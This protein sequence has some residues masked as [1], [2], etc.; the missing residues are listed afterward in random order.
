LAI[1]RA[2]SNRFIDRSAPLPTGGHLE[3]ADGTAWVSLF[4]E[5]MLE[6]SME[7]AA[8]D[9]F[10]EDMAVKFADHILWIARAMNQ[11]G[12]DGMW[13]EED[14]FYYDVLRLPDGKAMRLKVRSMVGVLPL[15]ASIVIEPWQRQRPLGRSRV[16]R[17][18]H[19]SAAQ[20]PP[21]G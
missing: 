11:A 19:T 18:R 7:V 17:A 13:D 5:N 4:C 10:Y 2:T 14:G 3:Q 21:G 15:C 1:S 16:G 6:I 8:H 12:P 9:S 20:V